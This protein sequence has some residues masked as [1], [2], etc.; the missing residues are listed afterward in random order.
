MITT[1]PVNDLEELGYN[2]EHDDGS[3]LIITKELAQQLHDTMLAFVI[4]KDQLED[5]LEKNKKD[6]PRAYE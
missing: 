6:Y 5:A 3:A 4:L 1:K 2:L